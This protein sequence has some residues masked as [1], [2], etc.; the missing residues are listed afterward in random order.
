MM[1]T[2]L[3]ITISADHKWAKGS[4]LTV[5]SSCRST[6]SIVSLG[7]PV[8]FTES[9]E[10]VSLYPLI[11]NMTV[12]DG[13]SSVREMVAVLGIYNIPL[14]FKM[15]VISCILGRHLEKY[16]DVNEVW[17]ITIHFTTPPTDTGSTIKG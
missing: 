9:I 5:L 14:N 10:A 12:V 7:L 17:K 8:L 16:K 15:S 4:L 1:I 13:T 11:I 3:L 6:L 2:I